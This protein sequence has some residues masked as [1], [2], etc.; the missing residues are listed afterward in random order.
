MLAAVEAVRAIEPDV[1]PEYPDLARVGASIRRWWRVMVVAALLFGALGARAIELAATPYAATAQVL[2]GPLAGELSVLRAAGQ[3]AQTYADLAVSRP[4]LL[5]TLRRLKSR[6]PRREFAQR[7]QVDAI[8]ETRLLRVTVRAA[9]PSDAAR[10][11]NVLAEEVVRASAAQQPALPT[12]T[13]KGR[14]LARLNP[15]EAAAA[16]RLQVMESA[17]LRPH[18]NTGSEDLFIAL[19][20][21]AGALL[22]LVVGVVVDCVRRRVETLDELDAVVPAPAIGRLRA[23]TL[24]PTTVALSGARDRVLVGEVG[25][26]AAPTALALTRSLAADGRHVL[27][28]DADARGRLAALLA[29]TAASGAPHSV[30]GATAAGVVALDADQRLQVLPRRR[31]DDGSTSP[32][33]TLADALDVSPATGEA[34][35]VCTGRALGTPDARAFDSAVLAVAQGRAQARE[36]ADAVAVLE[37]RGWRVV[38]TVLVER[39]RLAPV[40]MLRGRVGRRRGRRSLLRARGDVAGRDPA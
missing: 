2:V 40:A 5:A 24:A 21:L 39:P 27:L 28:V 13:S 34:V 17:V 37:R 29:R 19:A 10:Q 1:R 11:A 8:S 25:A 35:I 26:G 30:A 38:G 9:T 23:G 31:L 7:I 4:V 32:P 22:V 6:E 33:E 15:A 18:T 20:A 3:Q 36:V 16:V 14:R 12:G